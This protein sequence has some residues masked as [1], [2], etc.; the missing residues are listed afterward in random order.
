[1]IWPL[2]WYWDYEAS[3]KARDNV[4]EL[5]KAHILTLMYDN[6]LLRA[7]VDPPKCNDYTPEP[8]KIEES[9]PVEKKPFVPT[10]SRGGWRGK[11][12]QVSARTRTIPLP[13]DSVKA[14]EERVRRE[15]GKV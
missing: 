10:V 14:L 5:Q 6:K 1:M 11:S 15:G 9:V 2:V 4:I 3:I 7:K 8:P 13:K 12:A